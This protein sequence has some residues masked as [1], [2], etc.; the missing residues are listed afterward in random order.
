MSLTNIFDKE[1]G[2]T[3]LDFHA[4]VDDR[5]ATFSVIE[6]LGNRYGS[7]ATPIVIG[8]YNPVSW[9][10]HG[11]TYNPS[12]YADR[13]AFVFN[14]TYGVFAEQ[15]QTGVRGR[16]QTYNSPSYGPT[17]GGGHDIWVNYRLDAGY[18]FGYSYTTYDYFYGYG[19][20]YG[21]SILGEYGAQLRFGR[22]EVFA[23]DAAAVPEPGT[24]ALLGLGLLGVVLTRRSPRRGAAS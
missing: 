22:I 14:L 2:D 7:F 21:H 4:A 12:D 6:V 8:G 3:S 17:F 20:G 11:Y 10:S 9:G 24:P 15:Q 16:Y 1:A 23:V 5:G 19:Y 18:A 13:D